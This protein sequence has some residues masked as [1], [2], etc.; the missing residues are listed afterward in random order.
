[1]AGLPADAT[2]TVTISDGVRTLR[3]FDVNGGSDNLNQLGIRN[4]RLTA[5]YS[6]DADYL[7]APGTF[8]IVVRGP[9]M[10]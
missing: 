1:M 2:G 8:V 5:A 9:R 7:G 10:T 3:T 4:H 6:G